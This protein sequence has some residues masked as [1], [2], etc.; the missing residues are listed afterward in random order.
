MDRSLRENQTH[1]YERV[2]LGCALHSA[3]VARPLLAGVAPFMFEA[4]LLQRTWATLGRVLEGATVPVDMID[5]V[6]HELGGEAEGPSKGDL[7]GY[8]SAVPSVANADYYAGRVREAYA[9]RELKQLAPPELLEKGADLEVAD[10]AAGIEARARHLY[11]LAAGGADQ[12]L[13][14]ASDYAT[15]HQPAPVVWRDTSEDSSDVD[16]VLST[17]EVAI[18]ASAG[19]LGK[20]TLTLEMASAAAGA[21]AQCR[22][23]GKVC[24]L[25]V[26]PGP[27]ALVSYEDAPAR[28]AHRLK[29]TN[30]GAVP[31]NVH[32]WPDPMPLWMGA[33]DYGG[34]SRA[35]AWWPT[36]W[37]AVRKVGARLVVIDPV[38]AALADA[39]TSETGPVRA[40]LRALAREAAPNE[41]AGWEG[42]G[43]L[44]VAHD[45][46]SARDAVRK[47]ED[48]GSGVVAG[49][50]AW[51]D[52]ARGVLSLMRD[53]KEASN[54]RLLECVKA[55]YGRIGWGA[56]LRERTVDG[57]FR[58]LEWS[59]LLS[60]EE[61][62]T[63]KKS[64]TRN[65]KTAAG[66]TSR[67][68][69]QP[70]KPVH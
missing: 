59:E 62:S 27:V 20:S 1:E 26:T 42:C 21:I 54:D 25:R 40:F 33:T 57:A 7:H 24:G 29:W 16:A 3:D 13:R 38:S 68:S 22:H 67:T 10:L 31:E 9:W 14:S 58:G 15:V 63:A 56:R 23:Y 35:G 19:G 65:Q 47:G 6:M 2:L 44:L 34:E 50:A 53:P 46:K 36:F 39:S 52:G 5:A 18:L 17:G 51:Y 48:P 11:D 70:W 4:A 28:I 49:S 45:T 43:V 41:D 69:E 61:M 60:R 64:S 12:V 32:L 55:N 8:L 30:S 37:R 66:A